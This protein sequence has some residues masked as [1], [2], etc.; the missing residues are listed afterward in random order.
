MLWN[1]GIGLGFG[2]LHESSTYCNKECVYARVAVKYSAPSVM[3]CYKIRCVR[4]INIGLPLIE[5]QV[6]IGRLKL[7][8]LPTT[9]E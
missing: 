9:A 7:V 4:K 8:G 6:L 2:A 3:I 1:V 5:K